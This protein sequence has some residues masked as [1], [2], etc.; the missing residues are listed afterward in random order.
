MKRLALVLLLSLVAVSASAQTVCR[1][2]P[3]HDDC[4]PGAVRHPPVSPLDQ[5]YMEAAVKAS[6]RGLFGREPSMVDGAGKD[7][8]C[9]YVRASNHYGP[10][11]DGQCHAGWSGYWESWLQNGEG[12]IALVQ[13]PARFLPSAAPVPPPIPPQPPP[14]PV[15]DLSGVY[16]QFAALNGK[17]DVLTGKVD[18]TYAEAHATR[19][20]IAN[21]RSTIE[22]FF[23]NRYV[24]MALSAIASG[25]IVRQVTK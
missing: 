8:G 7:D 23:G 12:N 17:V 21:A 20:D 3:P 24:Q 19:E 14:V 18:A 25:E 5:A 1:V 22:K 9:Y 4:P 11:G 16:A 15:L 6:F 13:T 10:T 2:E